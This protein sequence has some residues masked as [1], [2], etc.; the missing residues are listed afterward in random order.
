MA[1]SAVPLGVLLLWLPPRSMFASRLA[2][3][4]SFATAFLPDDSMPTGMKVLARTYSVKWPSAKLIKSYLHELSN[5][6]ICLLKLPQILN[7]RQTYTY[8]GSQDPTEEVKIPAQWI[9]KVYPSKAWQERDVIPIV[10][11]YAL[12][13]EAWKHYNLKAALNLCK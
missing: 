13:Q 7:H 3:I 9:S 8:S 2:C 10:I 6:F 12:R 5:G 1:E 4:W 11:L